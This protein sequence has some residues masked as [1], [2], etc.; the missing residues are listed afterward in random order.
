MQRYCSYCIMPPIAEASH[1]AIA[2]IQ[3]IAVLWQQFKQLQ[4]YGSNYNCVEPPTLRR[5][6]PL[7]QLLQLLQQLHVAANR[8]GGT[9]Y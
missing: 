6:H 9:P 3:A 5:R 8:L 7:Q 4:C 1:P 2:A